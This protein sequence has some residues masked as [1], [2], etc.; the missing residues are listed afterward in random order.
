MLSSNLYYVADILFLTY[1]LARAQC[2]DKKLAGDL[3]GPFRLK[4]YI[5]LVM[6]YLIT[7]ISGYIRFL[8][9]NNVTL[10]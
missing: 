10:E 3:Q 7:D 9:S 4:I 1:A 2:R 6:K 5:D 8:T